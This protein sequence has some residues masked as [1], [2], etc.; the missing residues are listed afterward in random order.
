MSTVTTT[1][2]A[3]PAPVRPPS[4]LHRLGVATALHP[5]RVV[6]V[7]TVL[8]ACAAVSSGY[9]S[10][11][12]TANSNE[13]KGS[14]SA[15]AA[16]AVRHAFPD[17]PAETAF[18]VV[19]SASL[20]S[21]DA[22]F[23]QVVDAALAAYRHG[24]RV[25]GTLDPYTAPEQLLSADRHT[26]LVPLSLAGSS[27]ELRD[28]SA[29]LG[30]LARTLR[31]GAVEVAFTGSSALTAATVE[32]GSADLG[33]AESIGF[34]AAAVVLLL[35]FGSLVASVIPLALGA[36]A[37]V[38]A[39][40]VLGVVAHVVSFDVF[41]QTA[42]SMVAIALGID[43]SLFILTRFREELVG[44]DRHDRAAR[45]EAV[46]RTLAT[47]GHAVLFSGT[48][49]VASITGLWLVRTE[50]M[51]SM[52]MGMTASVLVMML[53]SM[54]LLPALLGLLGPGINRLA[55]PWAR[56]QLA[57]PDPERSLWGR[58]A[59]AVMRRPVLVSA[60]TVLILGA[61]AAPVAGLRQGVD[62]GA[63]SIA[64][65]DAGKGFAL[66][67]NSFAPGILTPVQVVVTTGGS[68]LSDAQLDAVASF[69]AATA[70]DS[71]VVQV[72]SLP[73]LLD[74][75]V[76]SHA[77]AA[78]RQALAASPA[79]LAG[80]VDRG[81]T[82]T[83]VTVR[84]RAAADTDESAALV[85]DLRARATT[86]LGGAGLTAHVGGSPA[87]IADV[88]RESTRVMPLVISVVLATSWVL[89]LIAFR[90]LLLPFSAILMNLLTSGA[91]F[92]TAVLVFQDGHGAAALGVHRTGFIQ[93][94]LPLLA[95]VLVFGVSMD[96]EV[97]M[98]SRMR[99]E[100]DR[101][102]DNTR[103]VRT[104]MAHTARVITS[105]AAIMIVVFGSFMFT[106]V[107]DIKQMGFM[108]GLAVL[109]DATVVRLLLVPSLMR[110]LGRW[111]W[112]LPFQRSAP[113]AST[114]RPTVSE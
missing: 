103:A 61:L 26:A 83:V 58:L 18:A 88:Q 68:G 106:S 71:R 60:T 22:A 97:F 34:P 49:V 72:V 102:G 52:A 101:T 40:G 74:Q 69:S 16:D 8:L 73:G 93:A 85:R 21:D 39:T 98:L 87:Q 44:V 109:I 17:A 47:A 5:W 66:V 36:L 32:Q 30:D 92:G 10:S 2:Q 65:S 78:L 105:A 80:V 53:L 50:K 20:R 64:G 76:H 3:A 15:Q 35:A 42:V 99:E 89:L 55:M 91:A 37:V 11:H 96:Y 112:W 113:A 13:V 28:A 54:T 29:P 95:F 41:V 19:H 45:A 48:T 46:G 111:N 114:V 62:L 12:L 82:T 94:M 110:L 31:S 81:A 14:D 51:R 1:E 108:L 70:T 84:P 27:G 38:A 25:T 24:P 33:L 57:H 9:F 75:A 4:R 23:H 86:V 63:G 7:W 90:S 107:V 100:W 6:L 77:G 59:S 43:Y 104:G 67:S 79:Q 56:S